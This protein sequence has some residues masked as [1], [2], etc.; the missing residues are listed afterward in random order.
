MNRPGY[1]GAVC[2]VEYQDVASKGR[3]QHPRFVRWRDDKL[4]EE[5]FISQIQ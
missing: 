1:K 5:C 3:L 4:A 2:E